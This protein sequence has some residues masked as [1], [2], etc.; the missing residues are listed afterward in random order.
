MPRCLKVGYVQE[1]S[2]VYLVVHKDRVWLGSGVLRT[3]VHKVRIHSGKIVL[4]IHMFI[5]VKIHSGSEYC[6]STLHK[7]TI[8]PGKGVLC[9]SIVTQ[10]LC[11]IS[12]IRVVHIEIYA[13]RVA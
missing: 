12:K 10:V 8:R 4:R 6:V 7:S 3:K 11:S 9:I 5:T 2:T 1:K 13:N